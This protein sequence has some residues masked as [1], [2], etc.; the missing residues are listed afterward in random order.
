MKSTEKR[1]RKPTKV[2]DHAQAAL[3]AVA[4]KHRTTAYRLATA[5]S[6]RLRARFKRAAT[7]RAEGR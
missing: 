1:G 6:G 7:R 2:I 4:K 5:V 3:E